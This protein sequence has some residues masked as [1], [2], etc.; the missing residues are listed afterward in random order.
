MRI[1]GVDLS[2]TA[3]GIACTC[4]TSVFST[5]KR[6]PERLFEISREVLSHATGVCTELGL[7]PALCV[8]EGYSYA[9]K[10]RGEVMGELG[11]CVRMTLWQNQVAYVDVAPKTLKKFATNAGNAGKDLMLAAAIRSWEYEGSNNNEADAW[12]L[13]KM[14]WVAYQGLGEP[15]LFSYQREAVGKVD[16]PH[17]DAI[18]LLPVL[19]VALDGPP[20]EVRPLEASAD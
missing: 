12:L 2:L 9:S 1:C 14:G 6:G 4:G 19:K 5:K 18:T 16:W 15:S 20:V 13:R 11:G 17:P 3:T 8:I 10:F 7:H